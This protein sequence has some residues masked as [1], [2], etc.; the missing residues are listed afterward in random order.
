MFNGI[1]EIEIGGE[2]RGFR[3]SLAA[4]DHFCKLENCAWYEMDKVLMDGQISTIIN[5]FLAGA[6]SYAKKKKLTD[7]ID[8]DTVEDWLSELGVHRAA[9]E[10]YKVFTLYKD[11]NEKNVSA[12]S[13]TG[14]NQSDGESKII[15]PSLSEN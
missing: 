2:K 14:Q 3:F 6:L 10:M 11:P 5:F 9:E 15:S 12:P 13:Q 1:V 4:L 7:Q 8:Y